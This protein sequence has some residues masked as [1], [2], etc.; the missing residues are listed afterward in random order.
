MITASFRHLPGLGSLR[1]RQ[2][3]RRGIRT[4]ADLPEMGLVLSP[5]LDDG[6]RAGVAESR[7]RFAGGALDWFAARLP[8]GEQWRLLPH[9][10]GDAVFLDIE[11][12]AMARQAG[13][14][15]EVTVIGLYDAAGAQALLAG[16]DL[17]SFPERVGRAR[18]LITYNGA[19]FD[20]PILKR[21]FPRWSPPACHIDLC[22]LWRRLGERG[23]LKTL[24]PRVGLHRPPHLA[25][26]SGAD[27][28][29]L[30][31]AKQ[32]GDPAALR[33]LVEYCLTDAAHL[34]T[35]AEEGY[36]RMLRKTGMAGAP[37]PVSGR[38][39][40]LYDLQRAVERAVAPG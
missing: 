13:E 40:V 23:G 11:T 8:P 30:W 18:A 10:L 14:P 27:A 29:A 20:L 9:L 34:K 32:R 24:E 25:E 26:L 7:A 28:A 37:L 36:N 33:R 17:L 35:L 4:W 1:E 19:A 5:K 31:Q 21:A 2:L 38:G 22:P 15:A 3:W 16:R 39:A 6:L 12:A